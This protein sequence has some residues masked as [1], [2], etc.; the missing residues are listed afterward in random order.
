MATIIAICSGCDK[1]VPMEIDIAEEKFI[2]NAMK[3]G[4]TCEACMLLRQDDEC[5]IKPSEY[6]LGVKPSLPYATATSFK[7]AVEKGKR[8]LGTLPNLDS[9]IPKFIIHTYSIFHDD[10]VLIMRECN[11]GT[12]DRE[13]K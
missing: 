9:L 5:Y 8:L 12:F 11:D 3:D 13:E 1:E 2:G 10:K 7:E 4:T 6:Q